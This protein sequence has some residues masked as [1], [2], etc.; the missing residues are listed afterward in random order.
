MLK[1]SYKKILN[2]IPGPDLGLNVL[3]KRDLPAKLSMAIALAAGEINNKLQA[4][5][6]VIQSKSAEGVSQED[7][8]KL[9]EECSS[10]E[11]EVSILPIPIS[12]FGDEKLTP[13][14]LMA[15]SWFIDGEK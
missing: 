2:T 12:L 10:L 3:I 8:N 1:V 14:E 6:K 7:L 13:G 5:Q 15:I 4:F 9:A 11:V